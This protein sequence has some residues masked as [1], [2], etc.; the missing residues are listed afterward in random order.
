MAIDGVSGGQTIF[1]KEKMV[2]APNEKLKLDSE[3]NLANAKITLDGKRLKQVLDKDDFLTLLIQ[4]LRHQDPTQPMQDREF[5]AQM[6]QFSSL[7]QTRNMSE[8]IAGVSR[9]VMAGQAYSM[10]GKHVEVADGSSM[11][12]GL[13]EKVIGGEVP[14]VMIDGRYYDMTNV[15]SVGLNGKGE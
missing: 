12:E 15:S 1:S 6:A 4:E 5:I 8:E 13:V 2:L 9:L 11:V 7:E 14:Q 3:V 10:L